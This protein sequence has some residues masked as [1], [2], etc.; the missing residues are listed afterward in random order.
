[1]SLPEK[2]TIDQ[3]REFALGIKWPDEDSTRLVLITRYTN[4]H[5]LVEDGCWVACIPLGPMNPWYVDSAGIWRYKYG[6]RFATADLAYAAVRR[7]RSITQSV[8]SVELGRKG[9]D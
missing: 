7:S 8:E 6:H 9:D 5:N 3:A 2:L 4:H 1:M